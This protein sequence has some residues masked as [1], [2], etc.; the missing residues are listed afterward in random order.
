MPTSLLYL[1]CVVALYLAWWR[2]GLKWRKRQTWDS[3]IG[4]LQDCRGRELSTQF[5]W[6]EGLTAGPEETW[7]RLGGLR[8]LWSLYSNTRV[9]MEMAEFAA[10]DA[11]VDAQML[12]ILRCD[13]AQIRFC[14]MTIVLQCFL[15]QAN[16]GAR[17]QAFRAASVYTG[18]AARMAE[19]LRTHA[20]TELPQFVAAM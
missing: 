4:R 18:M 8:G 13:A 1:M 16:E 15:Y 20:L 12:E 7:D 9:M 2:S 5:L 10:S 19:L 6:R 11:G 17:I 3:L 14:V